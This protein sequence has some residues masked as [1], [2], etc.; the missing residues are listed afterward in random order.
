MLSGLNMNGLTG[1]LVMVLTGLEVVA[2]TGTALPRMQFQLEQFF[3]VL[4]NV[5]SCEFSDMSDNAVMSACVRARCAV[6]WSFQT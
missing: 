6:G 4:N 3:L 5:F 1:V 2:K